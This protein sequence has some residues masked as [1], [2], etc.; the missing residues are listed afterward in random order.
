VTDNGF[1]I[2][3]DKLR[4]AEGIVKRLAEPTAVRV[5]VSRVTSIAAQPESQKADRSRFWFAHAQPKGNGAFANQESVARTVERPA[6]EPRIG[7]E[8]AKPNYFERAEGVSREH[9][10]VAGRLRAVLHGSCKRQHTRS[11]SSAGPLD[12]SGASARN[13]I[14]QYSS[15]LPS[16]ARSRFGE[17]QGQED[18]GF[19]VV[20]AAIDAYRL[21][22][23]SHL[24]Q[25]HFCQTGCRSFTV[26]R[27][28]PVQVLNGGNEDI[29][30]IPA[31][32]VLVGRVGWSAGE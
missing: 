4:T 11:A 18:V 22:G 17:E 15:P 23:P 13:W 31:I 32:E 28:A 25:R 8:P 12:R 30:S 26:F 2:G 9:N 7:A 10:E 3:R 14:E 5:R 6:T 29:H 16:R 1:Y 27:D 19:A 21:A 24:A 20:A